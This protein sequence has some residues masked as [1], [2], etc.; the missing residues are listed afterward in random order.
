MCKLSIDN[1]PVV[2]HVVCKCVLV[3]IYISEKQ[4]CYPSFQ[5][6]LILS[7]S[8]DPGVNCQTHTR[9]FVVLRVS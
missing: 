4:F 6:T 1:F 7:R 2:Q 5:K 9:K 3:D 8:G